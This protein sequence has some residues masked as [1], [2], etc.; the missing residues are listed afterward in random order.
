[1]R[2]W[3]G[4]GRGAAHTRSARRYINGTLL[5]LGSQGLS[6]GA[7]HL[8]TRLP[9]S[10]SAIALSG[11]STGGEAPPSKQ[12]VR[13]PTEGDAPPRFML[14]WSSAGR[15]A[16]RSAGRFS[17]ERVDAPRPAM[18][19]HGASFASLRWQSQPSQSFLPLSR[20]LSFHCEDSR[21]NRT[22]LRASA[23]W[24]LVTAPSMMLSGFRSTIFEAL[25][26]SHWNR[27]LSSTYRTKIAGC[28]FR[29]LRDWRPW[30][31]STLPTGNRVEA[32]V[33]CTS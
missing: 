12:I 28:P 32:M 16:S 14:A 3:A 17:P 4:G 26:S 18:H 31:C 7:S 9:T 23:L 2:T 13:V 20:L 1:M 22:R 29:S 19:T 5:S 6:C 33:V 15:L 11:S 21:A 10:S 30:I 27:P 25:V 24:Q 8:V